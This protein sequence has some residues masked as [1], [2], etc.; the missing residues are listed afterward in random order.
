MARQDRLVCWGGGGGL[1]GKHRHRLRLF[2]GPRFCEE[3]G[4][5]RKPNNST[6]GVQPT[7]PQLFGFEVGF[8]GLYLE[9][10]LLMAEHL[11][12]FS[13]FSWPISLDVFE[14]SQN[15]VSRVSWEN[16]CLKP[17][18]LVEHWVLHVFQ[19]ALNWRI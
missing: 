1:P 5:G 11:D 7:K 2:S 10:S 14:R 4:V 12:L 18:G 8:F 13:V 6:R 15:K 16:I 19:R 17:S 9:P 3:G